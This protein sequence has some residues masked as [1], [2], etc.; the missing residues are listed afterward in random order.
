MGYM[1][2]NGKKVEF[3]DE[4]NVYILEK[5]DLFFMPSMCCKVWLTGCITL[6]NWIKNCLPV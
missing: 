6:T 2:I 1:T 4:K 5:T 3:T